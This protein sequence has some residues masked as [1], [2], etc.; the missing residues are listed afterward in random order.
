MIT[1]AEQARLTKAKTKRYTGYLERDVLRRVGADRRYVKRKGYL[2]GGTERGLHHVHVRYARSSGSPTRWHHVHYHGLENI[3]AA[4]IGWAREL[5]Q[6]ATEELKLALRAVLAA[7][8]DYERFFFGGGGYDEAMPLERAGLKAL[9]RQ[10]WKR[11][12]EPGAHWTDDSYRVLVDKTHVALGARQPGYHEAA[13]RLWRARSLVAI[14]GRAHPRTVSMRF[15][16]GFEH[17]ATV[18][19]AAEPAAYAPTASHMEIR[20]R[21]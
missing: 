9:A 17:A 3:A 13:A 8:F 5:E 16:P 18:Y 2:E 21:E 15:L 4:R 12:V 6:A 20:F 14:R 11:T 1:E 19:F 10:W 7:R